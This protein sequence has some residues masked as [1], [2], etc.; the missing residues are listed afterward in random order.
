MEE[1]TDSYYVD[2][3]GRRELGRGRLTL[4]DPTSTLGGAGGGNNHTC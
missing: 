1:L 2:S 4:A 3:E